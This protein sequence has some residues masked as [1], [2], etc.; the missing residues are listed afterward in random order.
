[1]ARVLF[2]SK[3]IRDSFFESCRIALGNC[4]WNKL[5]QYLEIHRSLGYRYKKGL[6]LLPEAY[7]ER[8]LQRLNE[9]KISF[10]SGNISFKEDNWGLKKGGRMAYLQNKNFFKI[11]RKKGLKRLL[12]AA[13][14]KIHRFNVRQPL[15]LELCE[16][17]GA[18]IGDGFTANYNGHCM[19]QF[20]GD[21]RYDKEYY[22]EV[23]VPFAKKLFNKNPCIREKENFYRVTYNSKQLF[24]FL[25]KRFKFPK[26]IKSYTVKIPEPII[27]R[28]KQYV[29]AA[30]RGIFDTDG[31]IFY[32]KRAC[33]KRPYPRITFN[34][35][36]PTLICQL[37]DLFI[38]YGFLPSTAEHNTFLHLY[39]PQA[40]RFFK[41]IS[42]SNT[43]HLRRYYLYKR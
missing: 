19:T 21:R 30:I 28:G 15:T 22:N 5:Y 38:E 34:L 8:L 40:D 39:G 23:I 3:S 14:R 42:S 9:R 29:Y 32:D 25:T 1:M 16:F 37:K 7:Y 43:K 36:N 4:S 33:Y 11:G 6:L 17:L 18:F 27:K 35:V 20:T 26:G 24:I 41:E 10:F 31:C 2:D 12:L 13:Q